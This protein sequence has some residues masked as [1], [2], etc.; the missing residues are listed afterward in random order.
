MNAVAQRIW[1][2]T[3]FP[4]QCLVDTKRTEAFRAAILATV[5][6]GDVVLDAGSGSGILSF[7]AAEAGAR[8]V[9]A[10]EIDPFLAECLQRSVQANGLS[11]TIKV[12]CGD[13][14]SVELPHRVDVFIGEMIDT[15]L[16]DELQAVAVNRLRAHGVLTDKTRMI[17]ASYDTFIELGLANLDYYGYHILMPKHRWPHYAFED[18]GW[19]PTRFEARTE[20]TLV[21]VVDFGS[22]IETEVEQSFAFASAHDCEINAIRVSGCA[23]LTADTRLGPTN[24]FNGDKIFP[25][26]PIVLRKGH[27][28]L[29]SVRFTLGAGLSSLRIETS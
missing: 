16:M 21:A 1:S 3:D 22:R 20:P 14:C 8:A 18:A 5:K 15:G 23:H 7:F 25:I 28:A 17:P 24:A 9:L 26:D 10:V 2:G 27:A 6:P 12:I 11:K 13:V 4:Y 29:T 19:R